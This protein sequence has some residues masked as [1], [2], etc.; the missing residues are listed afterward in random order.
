MVLGNEKK[1]EKC[2]FELANADPWAETANGIS[3]TRQESLKL[4]HYLPT[5]AEAKFGSGNYDNL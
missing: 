4:M 5:K 3:R 2:E 1:L